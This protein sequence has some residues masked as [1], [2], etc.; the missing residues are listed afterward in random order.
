MRK[1]EEE[2]GQ[3][4]AIDEAHTHTHTHTHRLTTETLQT[5]SKWE[6]VL[7][8]ESRIPLS[9]IGMKLS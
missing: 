5:L 9:I 4:E 2:E 3:Q 8:G 1:A 6:I 7:F